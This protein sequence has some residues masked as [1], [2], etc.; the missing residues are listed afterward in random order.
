MVHR[1]SWLL[2]IVVALAEAI[3]YLTGV[4]IS[5][6]PSIALALVKSLAMSSWGTYRT[7]R[8]RARN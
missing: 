5:R 2:V 3:P 8:L 1:C 4:I 7:R 6:L